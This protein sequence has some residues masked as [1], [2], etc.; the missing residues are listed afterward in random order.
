MPLSQDKSHYTETIET[1]SYDGDLSSNLKL[2]A[3]LRHMQ[4]IGIDHIAALEEEGLVPV[5]EDCAFVLSK[6][7]LRIVRL[8]KAGESL[9][10][11]TA[12]QP[13]VK[14]QFMR[15][16]AMFDSAGE[17]VAESMT[18]WLLFDFAARKVMRPT[19]YEFGF[20]MKERGSISGADMDKLRLRAPESVREA[21]DRV[22]RYSDID[23]NHHLNNTVYADIVCDTLPFELMAAREPAQ[24]QL[25]FI[26]E[27]KVGEVLHLCVG[28]QEGAYYVGGTKQEDQ[29]CFAARLR[30]KKM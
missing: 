16:Y 3:I 22:I 29:A 27:A 15:Y 25:Q 26:K 4:Q 17:P 24:L 23:L 12:P 10:I 9:T 20:E 21:P 11:F 6:L 2:S 13:S 14:A 8:P 7:D 5:L 1:K 19:V 28:E 30:F 18:S